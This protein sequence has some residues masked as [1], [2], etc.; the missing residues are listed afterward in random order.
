M[1]TGREVDI[2]FAAQK[3]ALLED[4]GKVAGEG[5]CGKFRRTEKHMGEAGVDRQ[6]GH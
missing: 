5:A 2:P 3:V 4:G 6:I 1:N